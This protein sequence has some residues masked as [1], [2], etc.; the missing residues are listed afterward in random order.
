MSFSSSPLLSLE[1]RKRCFA[2]VVMEHD[3]LLARG[4]G[5]AAR[6]P[7]KLVDCGDDV[8]CHGENRATKPK[9]NPNSNTVF[10]SQD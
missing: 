5:E 4:C 2:S 8:M 3:C 7:G 10:C 6:T 1:L 9:L